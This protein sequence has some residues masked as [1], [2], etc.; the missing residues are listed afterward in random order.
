MRTLT[1]TNT[2][3]AVVCVSLFL[4]AGCGEKKEKKPAPKPG[5][6]REPAAEQG[7]IPPSDQEGEAL[8]D[9]TTNCN[10][11][12]TPFQLVSDHKSTE[13]IE[14]R[15]E[16]AVSELRV[17]LVGCEI[18]E[19]SPARDD[20]NLNKPPELYVIVKKGDATEI[21]SSAKSGW[22]VG[23]A[24]NREHEFNATRS[25]NAKYY[26]EIL[27]NQWGSD[28]YVV[29]IG[30]VSGKEIVER[31]LPALPP[32]N[33]RKQT[34]LYEKESKVKLTFE[35]VG[36][37]RW[38]RLANVTIPIGSPCRTAFGGGELPELE[39]RLYRDG[40]PLKNVSEET[41]GSCLPEGWEGNYPKSSMNCWPILEQSDVRYDLE[42]WDVDEQ[43]ELLFKVS[44]LPGEKF[45]DVIFEK[46]GPYDEEEIL[47]KAQFQL[48]DGPI[49]E[50]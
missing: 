46:A 10:R 19:D 47:G 12:R 2:M 4:L 6:L 50:E 28:D 15:E 8:R 17:R 26:F 3:V 29:I 33:K 44:D 49:T 9:T 41:T 43:N 42:V 35:Y 18:G 14:K 24:N 34:E 38:H 31:L 45:R 16:L 7:D 25:E 48:L 22:K 5:I 1:R 30:P 27:D 11:F 23:F 13:V 20:D 36:V 37:V 40:K 39:V 21:T 32:G